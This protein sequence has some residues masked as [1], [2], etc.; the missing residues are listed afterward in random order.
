VPFL[1]QSPWNAHAPEDDPVLQIFQS[2]LAEARSRGSQS[3][4]YFATGGLPP[5]RSPWRQAPR[6]SRPE[7]FF[8]L[9]P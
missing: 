9:N 6:D 2:N 4:S 7:F 3:Q 5:I 8:Q 1:V